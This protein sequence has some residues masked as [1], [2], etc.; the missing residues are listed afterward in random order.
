MTLDTI[1]N[2]SILQPAISCNPSKRG[3]FLVEYSIGRP[4]RLCLWGLT[5]LLAASACRDEVVESVE[6]SNGAAAI[7]DEGRSEREGAET[8]ASDQFG[9]ADIEGSVSRDL[10]SVGQDSRA[11]DGGASS[12]VVG[13][14]V[15]RAGD[16]PDIVGVSAADGE[17]ACTGVLIKPD[18]VLTAAHCALQGISERIHIGNRRGQW[19]ATYKVAR[20]RHAL[21]SPDLPA[22]CWSLQCGR[23]LAVLLLEGPVR[24]VTPRAYADERVVDRAKF[25]HVVG[26]GRTDPEATIRSETKREANVAAVSNGCEGRVGG[27]PD[28]DVYGCEAGQ[29]VVAGQVRDTADTCKGDSGGPLLMSADGRTPPATSARYRLAGIT[30]RPTSLARRIC[31]DGGVYERLT[32]DARAWID[33]TEAALRRAR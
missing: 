29:E 16:F 13:G 18:L 30:S 6:A 5:L 21:Q 20:S 2:C 24:D 3:G 26:F 32:S 28:R 1:L 25:Y 8:A 22:G 31:G 4:Q 27:R 19:D 9:I 14:T 12:K 17:V 10:P 33:R 11:Q 15:V 7:I 23:D